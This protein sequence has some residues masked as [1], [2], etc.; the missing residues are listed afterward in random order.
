MTLPPLDSTSDIDDIARVLLME[1]KAFDVFPTPVDR[2]ISSAE[3]TVNHQ[4]SLSEVQLDFFSG[5]IDVVSSALKKLLGLVDLRDKVIYLDHS[6]HAARKNF[7]KLHEV[8]HDA[9]PWQRAT[10]CF[11]DDETT[12]DPMVLLTFEREASHFA[13]SVLFQLDR[14][15]TLAEQMPLKLS[16]AMELARTFNASNQAAIRRYVE[17]SKK[18]C[19]CLVLERP[20]AQPVFCANVRNYFQS[21]ALQADVGN[22]I[23]PQTLGLEFPFILDLKLRRRLHE[24]GL[25]HLSST[26]LEPLPFD[27]HFFN[28]TYNTFVFLKP[29]GEEN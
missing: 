15:D 9:L 8:G 7:I 28:N 2:I 24:T 16:S 19:A 11:A 26:A 18:R 13:S 6:Q 12:I 14:F 23:W 4:I 3:L 21:P 1:S 17:H 25:V 29:R 27:Y 20:V 5:K 10:L 22:L